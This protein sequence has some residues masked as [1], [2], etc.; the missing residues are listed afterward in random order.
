MLPGE[1]Q[2]QPGVNAVGRDPDNDLSID[3]GSVAEQH[4]EIE[5]TGISQGDTAR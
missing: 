2:L 4:C 3:H 5:V 1:F